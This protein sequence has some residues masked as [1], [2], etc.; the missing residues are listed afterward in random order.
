MQSIGVHQSSI[1]RLHP[2]LIIRLLKPTNKRTSR[3]VPTNETRAAKKKQKRKTK[4]I[5]ITH[6]TNHNLYQ[7]NSTPISNI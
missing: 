1:T 7:L 5:L 3:V 4:K 6:E 2:C